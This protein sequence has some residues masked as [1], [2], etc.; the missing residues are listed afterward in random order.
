[1][2]QSHPQALG[3]IGLQKKLY[4]S[5]PKTAWTTYIRVSQGR[6]GIPSAC[7]Y[8]LGQTGLHTQ[9]FIQARQLN[10]TSPHSSAKTKLCPAKASQRAAEILATLL[11]VLLHIK[12]LLR[13]HTL[14]I[15]TLFNLR[16][17]T[18]S[19]SLRTKKH[20][21]EKEQNLLLFLISIYFPEPRL[22]LAVQP[23][24]LFPN[25]CQEGMG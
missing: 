14:A 12:L 13:F 9:G 23:E 5:P 6:R 20:P 16:T 10:E 25:H 17:E 3:S 15:K 24:M 2:S 21:A 7:Q 19:L 11:S 18:T 4:S 8:I 22:F 1:M